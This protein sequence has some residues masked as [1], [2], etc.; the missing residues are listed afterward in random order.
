MPGPTE[1][2]LIVRAVNGTPRRHAGAERRLGGAARR[3]AKPQRRQTGA[4][5]L[6]A[7]LGL[8]LVACSPASSGPAVATP[9]PA[10]SVPAA[11][12]GPPATA[13]PPPVVTQR[14]VFGA[15]AVLDT[16]L[17]A[18]NDL[19]LNPG[20]VI[21]ADGVLHMYPNSFSTWPAKV[22]VPHL[23]SEDGVEWTLE[24]GGLAIDA[25]KVAVANP[26]MDVST[27]F[28]ADDGTWVLVFETVTTSTPWAVHRATAPGPEGPWTTVEE[29]ILTPTPGSFDAGGV[30]WPSVVKVG[31]RWAMY[32]AGFDQVQSG[33]GA[34][35]VA[36]SDD[37]VTWEKQAEPVLLATERWEGRSLDRPRIVAVPDG[38]VMV[39]AGRD[40]NDRG[41][42]TSADGIT[43]T[44]V[45]GP[46]I[47]QAD[48]PIKQRSWDCALVY[49]DGQLEYWLEI[50]SQTTSV[51]RATLAWP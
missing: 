45:P 50:G 17:T 47:E 4:R 12:S 11:A 3:H 22:K 21:E 33:N 9:T 27:G 35:G 36:W 32:Y 16:E 6:A 39:Y 38:Y 15:A 14:F 5:F 30:R 46:N 10:A 42:A 44:K 29:A 37:G 31:D 34:I 41:I 18:T 25:A 20:A 43:W 13:T 26:G 24:D 8:A 40:L 28:I 51:F 2:A 7:A 23:T 49:R 19:Y 48:F 1:G